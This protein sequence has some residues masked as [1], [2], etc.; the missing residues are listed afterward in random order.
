MHYATFFKQPKVAIKLSHAFMVEEV[1]RKECN[2][3]TKKAATGDN[4]WPQELKDS[5][6]SF[7]ELCGVKVV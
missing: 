6:N 3:G 4:M 1:V 7:E 5:A 2:D